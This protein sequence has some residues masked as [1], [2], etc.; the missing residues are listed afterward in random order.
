MENATVPTLIANVRNVS[1]QIAELGV[2]CPHNIALSG[3]DEQLNYAGLE[4]KAN[5][6]AGYLTQFGVISGGTVAI[7]MERSFDWIVAALG[8]MRAGAAY[9]PLDPAWPDSR[10]RFAVED[11]GASVLVARAI[12]LERLQ[13]GAQ[14][15]DPRRDSVAISATPEAIPKPIDPKSLAYVI[16]TSGSTGVPKGVE[17]THSNLNHLIQ[18]HRN[19]LGVT[20]RDRAS[21]I[22]GLGFDAA[23]WEIWPNLAAGATVCLADDEVRSCPALLQQWIIREQV[24]LAFVPTVH[25]APMFVM[26]WPATTALRVLLTGGDVLHRAPAV[27]L[28][29]Q[30][31]NN[32]GP[33]ECTVVTTSSVLTPGALELPPIGR[34]VTGANVYLLD[35]QGAELG[36]GELGEIYIGGAGVGQ[37]YRK[38]P[39]ATERAFRPDPFSLSPDARMYRTGDRGLRRPDGQIEFRG[40]VDRQ[41]KI[42]GQ[43]VELDEIASVLKDHPTID[44]CTVIASINSD[45]E[46]H[47]VAHV[48][49]KQNVCAP[50]AYELQKYLLATLPDYMVPALFVRLE[51]L[52]L[53]PNGK[54]D[55][56]MLEQPTDKNRLERTEE[57]APATATAAKLLAIMQELL[58]NRSFRAEDNFFLAGGHSLLGM[59]LLLRLRSAFGV[60]LTIQQL[61][62]APTVER[63]ASLVETRL[64]EGRLSTIWA[65]LLGVKQVGLDVS[66]LDVGGRP[67][68]LDSL[69][70]RIAAEFDHDFTIAK[71]LQSPT[72]RQQAELIRG[73]MNHEIVLPPGVLALRARRSRKSIFWVHDLLVGL[74]KAFGEDLSLLFVK[75]TSEDV[76][77]IGQS[78]T[79]QGIAKCLVSKILATQPDGSYMIGGFCVGG[80]VAYEIAT[81]LRAD[82]HEVSLLVL[83]DPPS[84]SSVRRPHA[85]APKLSE[86]RYLL[87][88]VGRLGLR[89]SLVKVRGLI[90]ERVAK[91]SERTGEAAPDQEMIEKAACEYRLQ[92]YEG[93]VLLVLSSDHPPH[94]NL[95][96]GWQAVIPSN[97][98][99]EYVSGHHGDLMKE[100][101]VRNVADAIVPHLISK[102][103]DGFLAFGVR[104]SSASAQS[105]M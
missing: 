43:R 79:L 50:T 29:F 94:M 5:Q 66:F 44:F 59:Q 71:L 58:G 90:R 47:L 34:P 28:P 8:V 91:L 10:V 45:G 3:C 15:I 9:V 49:L 76:A 78:A 33:T 73:D 95:L 93:K 83:L 36:E 13:L 61:F 56:T 35:E 4:R 65:D 74:A 42:R 6:F 23:V 22:A 31:V 101:N 87:K 17:I 103:D 7:C 30:V 98:H 37:G 14:G 102:T 84:P 1:E 89:T 41:T 68:L 52:P 81:Q 72:V 63:L 57:K 51:T 77:S 54:I 82:G 27:Q 53:S 67:E 21:H 55:L 97:L 105:T 92:S 64:A 99:I 19:A 11:S 32:Y 25:A 104:A 70:R 12:L 26:D 69:R 80:I 20:Q 96:P 46:N 38:L 2:K 100:P 88:R 60:D 48:L 24:T 16:Y 18:W 40:R 39:D 85:W 86:P 75:L 62:E